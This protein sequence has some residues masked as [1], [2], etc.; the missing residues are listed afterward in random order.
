LLQPT[1]PL[2]TP[3]NLLTGSKYVHTPLNNVTKLL[4]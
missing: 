3:Q 4:E 1:V 2:H